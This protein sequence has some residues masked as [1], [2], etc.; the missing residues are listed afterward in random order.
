MSRSPVLADL[1]AGP[2]GE[3]PTWFEIVDELLSF[4]NRYVDIISTV[5]NHQCSLDAVEPVN[6]QRTEKMP[7]LLFSQGSC[8]W[9]CA[10]ASGVLGLGW[11]SFDRALE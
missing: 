10:R 2:T 7:S 9:S 6:R 3:Y 1:A 8:K 5:L 4:D 11:S